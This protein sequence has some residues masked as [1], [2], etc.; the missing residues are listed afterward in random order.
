MSKDKNG[1]IYDIVNEDLEQADRENEA[2]YYDHY[3]S[4]EQE[5]DR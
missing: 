4:E 3:A 2:Q 5:N 1:T